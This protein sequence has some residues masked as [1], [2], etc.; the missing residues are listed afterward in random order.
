MI[1][2]KSWLLVLLS[3]V[4]FLLSCGKEQP[5]EE[6]TQNG[7]VSFYNF[8]GNA[9]DDFGDNEGTG[10]NVEYVTDVSHSENQ[11]LKLNGINSYVNLSIPFDFESRTISLW[12]YVIES[13]S[14]LGVIYSSDNPTLKY[15][16]TILSMKQGNSDIELY[17]SASNHLDTINIEADTWYNAT[18]TTEN[19]NYSYYLNG[20]NVKSGVFEDFIC[21]YNGDSTSVFGCDRTLNQRFFKGLID[22][23]RVYNRKLDDHEIKTIYKAKFRY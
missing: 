20:Y 23:L 4:M 2:L 8:Q 3:I 18:I 6:P 10:M 21:S 5:D 19:K 1:Q 14:D 16:M 9:N 13:G 22:N 15:G 12:F 7:L 11:F 17:F